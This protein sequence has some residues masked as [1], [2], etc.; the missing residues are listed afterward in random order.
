[1]K[2]LKHYWKDVHTGEWCTTNN[3][4]EKR[5][6]EGE[7]PGLDVRI[8]LQDSAG[9]D[10]CMAYVPD[11]T[12]EED[13]VVGD[14]TAA[15]FL[16]ETQWNSVWTPLQEAW[17]ATGEAQEAQLS[18]DATTEATKRA[19]AETKYAEAQTAIQALE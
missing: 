7:Y 9:I 18:G 15:K 13:V 11:S 6:P 4:V 17:T 3:P 12:V 5:H 1:M 14:K 2:Y 16:T 8:W 19:L 10:V